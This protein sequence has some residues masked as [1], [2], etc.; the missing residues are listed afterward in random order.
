MQ[1]V[2]QG[3][4][5]NLSVVQYQFITP[6]NNNTKRTLTHTFCHLACVGK[7]FKSLKHLEEDSLFGFWLA[8]Q[9]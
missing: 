8:N 3:E 6:I 9:V 7:A 5:I 4:A 1:G 2:Y